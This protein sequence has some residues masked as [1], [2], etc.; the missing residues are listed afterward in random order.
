MHEI[1]SLSFFVLHTSLPQTSTA[2]LPPLD[3][4]RTPNGWVVKLELAGVRLQDVA[5]TVH[6]SQM[7]VAGVRRDWQVEAGWRHQSMEIAYN[8]FERTVT[9]PCDLEQAHIT[10]DY[11]DG[12]LL[13]QVAV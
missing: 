13:L 12:M 3:L 8:R 5:I 11:R 7:R 10:A 1:R 9:L 2:W 4:Y 6:G